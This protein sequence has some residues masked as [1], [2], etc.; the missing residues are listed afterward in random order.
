MNAEGTLPE[1]GARSPEWRQSENPFR[2][3]GTRTRRIAAS[4]ARASEGIEDDL[5]A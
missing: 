4:M 2:V 3:A 5:A 1:R